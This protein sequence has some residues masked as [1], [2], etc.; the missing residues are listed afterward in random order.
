MSHKYTLGPVKH[1]IEAVVCSDKL[2]A[3]NKFKTKKKT[4]IYTYCI[5]PTKM[6]LVN[7]NISHNLKLD[8][9]Y[10]GWRHVGR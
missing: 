2:M 8:P 5:K 1:Y 7:P 4:F 10:I 6:L 9:V 3:K